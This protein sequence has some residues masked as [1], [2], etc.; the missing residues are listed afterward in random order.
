MAHELRFRRRQTLVRRCRARHARGDQSHHAWRELRVGISRGSRRRPASRPRARRCPVHRSD[1]GLSNIAG[2]LDHGR[3]RLSRYEIPRSRGPLSFLRLRDRPPLGARRQ[4]RA[5]APRDAG[6]PAHERDRYHRFRARSAHGRRAARRLRQQHDPPAR[7]QSQRQRHTTPGHARRTPARSPTSRLSRSRPASSPTR[8][9]S[10]SGPITR[11][12]P[13]GS[14]CPTPP[15]LSVS[16]A[17]DRGRC[18][19]ALSG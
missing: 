18:P 11:K 17:T 8:P 7:L 6:P 15:Q 13:V 1:L 10:P 12:N 2:L 9:T 14:R 5:P 19:L 3:I 16:P 4:R